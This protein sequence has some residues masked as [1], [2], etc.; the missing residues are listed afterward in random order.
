MYRPSPVWGQV[1]CSTMRA[2]PALEKVAQSRAVEGLPSGV[3]E[4]LW[5]VGW[6][7]RVVVVIHHLMGK[8]DICVQQLC[9]LRGQG[10]VDGLVAPP[11]LILVMGQVDLHLERLQ[12]QGD[13]SVA[14]AA[15]LSAVWVEAAPLV[16]RVQQGPYAHKPDGR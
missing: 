8:A 9:Q 3:K 4:N 16:G 13:K 11:S 12:L 1:H 10:E 2:D 15:F 6:P 7:H 14:S 5:G